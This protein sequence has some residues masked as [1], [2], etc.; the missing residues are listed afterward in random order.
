[1]APGKTANAVTEALNAEAA[2]GWRCVS[3]VPDS[4]IVS[5]WALL[6]RETTK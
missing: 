1:M 5:L 2:H 3:L 4:N 6:E